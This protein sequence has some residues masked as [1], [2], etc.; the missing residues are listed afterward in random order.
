MLGKAK[1]LQGYK[2]DSLNGEIGS[3]RRLIRINIS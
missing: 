2:L 1:T 3:H